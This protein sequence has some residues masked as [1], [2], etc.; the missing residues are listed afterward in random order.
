M[1][2]SG[3]NAQITMKFALVFALPPSSPVSQ[4]PSLRLRLT[5]LSSTPM[6]LIHTLTPDSTTD[7]LDTTLVTLT[8]TTTARDLLMLRLSLRLR[9]IR[10]WLMVM[11]THMLTE[12][13]DTDTD[14]LMLTTATS[15]ARGPL[16]PSPRLMLMPTMVSMD[17]VTTDWD[18]E[19]TDTDTPMLTTATT[20]ARGP[21]TPSLRLMPMPTMATMATPGPTDTDTDTDWDTEDTTGDKFSGPEVQSRSSKRTSLLVI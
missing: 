20:T 14:T 13:T 8:L 11:V 15:T 10:G 21:L 1:G 4:R 19:L 16:M 9:L 3:L 7:M 6:V 5:P 12:D 17:W 2:I 18:T